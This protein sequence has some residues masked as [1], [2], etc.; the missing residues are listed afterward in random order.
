VDGRAQTLNPKPPTLNPNKPY[1]VDDL[2]DEKLGPS[3]PIK[4][5]AMMPRSKSTAKKGRRSS[6]VD[7]KQNT[8]NQLALMDVDNL[9]LAVGQVRSCLH[10]VCVCMGP[11]GGAR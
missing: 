2:L 9:Q 7:E 1:Q 4:A 5:K 11:H 6:T 3:S 10:C 8:H